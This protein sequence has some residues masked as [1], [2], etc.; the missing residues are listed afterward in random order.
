MVVLLVLLDMMCV[1]AAFSAG[2]VLRFSYGWLEFTP[3][4]PPPSFTDYAE[5]LVLVCVVFL[6]VSRSRGLYR[7]LA[8]RGIDVLKKSLEA[9]NLAAVVVL[10][11][12]DNLLKGAASQAVEAWQ[13]AYGSTGQSTWAPVS[14]SSGARP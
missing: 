1:A 3:V 13:S 4:D 8:P 2:Y 10:A 6:L 7:E 12:L 9:V 11:A 14:M 5:A